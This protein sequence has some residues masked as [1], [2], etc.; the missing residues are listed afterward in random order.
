MSLRLGRDLD[1]KYPISISTP[2][3]VRPS[4]ASNAE[5]VQQAL[6]LRVPLRHFR[7]RCGR[8]VVREYLVRPDV[9]PLLLP[10]TPV[11]SI[12]AAGVPL[13]SRS[14]TKST[15]PPPAWTGLWPGLFGPPSPPTPLPAW[16]D[17]ALFI[18]TN[19]CGPGMRRFWNYLRAKQ[20]G[21]WNDSNFHCVLC[22]PLMFPIGMTG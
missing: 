1:R 13:P 8:A 5:E 17:A 16:A 10:P 4:C 6:V 19:E 18:P 20:T 22:C 11:S 9:P 14:S 7:H 3:A 12:V 15:L 21:R 2:D